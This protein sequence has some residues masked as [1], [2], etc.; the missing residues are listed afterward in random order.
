MLDIKVLGPGCGNCFKLENMC[1]DVVAENNPEATIE[2]VTKVEDFW[3]YGVMLS[4]ALVVNG[5]VLLQGKIPTKHT[6]THWLN[7]YRLE[8][9][10][11]YW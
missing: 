10:K 4:P 5:K 9:L 11:R 1:R 3:K 6:L 2:K 8:L 7:E